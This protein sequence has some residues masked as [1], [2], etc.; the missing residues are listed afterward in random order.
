MAASK[1]NP[2]AAL[3]FLELAADNF[4]CGSQLHRQLLVRS[5]HLI[6]SLAD[7][8]QGCGEA[9]I[10]PPEGDFLNQH[11][12]AGYACSVSFEYKIAEGGGL[13]QEFAKTRNGQSLA[14]Y[15][16]F[17]YTFCVVVCAAHQAGRG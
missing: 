7:L 13:G 12:Q 14:F 9:L 15:I 6:I 16:G 10:N 1:F 17:G 3:E 11:Q 8:K 2:T 5:V 4:A